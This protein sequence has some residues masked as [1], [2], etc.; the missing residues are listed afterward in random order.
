LDTDFVCIRATGSSDDRDHFDLVVGSASDFRLKCSYIVHGRILW[1]DRR[2]LIQ[3]ERVVGEYSPDSPEDEDDHSNQFGILR[4]QTEC[5]Y[6]AHVLGKDPPLHRTLNFLGDSTYH[7]RIDETGQVQGHSVN[8]ES[9]NDKVGMIGSTQQHTDFLR[10]KQIYRYLQ[11]THFQ[12][13]AV[14]GG[15]TITGVDVITAINGSNTPL[16][17]DPHH[18]SISCSD[19]LRLKGFRDRAYRRADRSVHW[20]LAPPDI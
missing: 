13:Q 7:L 4:L 10:P 9:P 11:Q 3:E 20:L 12:Q 6:D 18:V 16:W 2:G 17:V 1:T 5:L 19:F 15:G 14:T 8:D